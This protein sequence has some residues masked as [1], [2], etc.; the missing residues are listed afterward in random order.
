MVAAMVAGMVVVRVGAVMGEAKEVVMGEGATTGVLVVEMGVETVVVMV[1]AT[2]E[3]G[4]GVAMAAEARAAGM[5]AEAME[6]E[7]VA[8]AMVVATEEGMVAGVWVEADLAMAGTVAEERA[9]RVVCRASRR[10]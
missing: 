2:V 10:G 7:M 6:E 5:V 9:G 8:V 1:V 3:E 4:T